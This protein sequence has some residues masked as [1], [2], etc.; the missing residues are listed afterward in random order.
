M[1]FAGNAA[2][3]SAG[4]LPRAER[5]HY[6]MFYAM[7]DDA[8]SARAEFLRF[9]PRWPRH[10]TAM[11]PQQQAYRWATIYSCQSRSLSIPLIS[12]GSMSCHP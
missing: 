9:A 7:Q 8:T 12:H 2:K 6:H 3:P 11:P 4:M 1:T 5:L 10:G